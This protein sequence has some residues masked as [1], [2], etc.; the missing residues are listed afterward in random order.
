MI[1]FRYT[2]PIGTLTIAEIDGFI[3][4]LGFSKTF[5]SRL[6]S[7]DTKPVLKETPVL[8]QANLELQKYFAHTLRQFTVPIRLIGTDFQKEVWKALAAIPYGTLV[9]YG[10]IAKKI[11]RPKAARAVGG[12]CNRNPILL[13]VPCHRVIGATGALTGFAGG[14]D[15]KEKL[16]SLEKTH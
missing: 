12:A 16:I 15:T 5:P 6:L 8:T 10:E 14:L 4:Y 13:I 1:F 11:N 7:I 3:V 9:S 2:Y